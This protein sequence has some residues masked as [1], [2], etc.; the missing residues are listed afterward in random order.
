MTAPPNDPRHDDL[1]AIKGIGQARQEWLRQALDIHTYQDLAALAPEALEAQLKDSGKV[2]S[3]SDIEMWIEQAQHLAAAQP[4]EDSVPTEDWKPFAS[5][6]IEFQ[7]RETAQGIDRR[8]RVHYMEADHDMTWPEIA[9]SEPYQWI[10]DQLGVE[11][12]PSHMISESTEYEEQEPAA[13]SPVEIPEPV[14]PPAQPPRPSEAP[15]PLFSAEMREV[16]AKAERVLGQQAGPPPV[17][18]TP[19]AVPPARPPETSGPLERENLAVHVTHIER[20][21][22]E[23]TSQSGRLALEAQVEV[24]N[25]GE[26]TGK[27]DI[28]FYAQNLTTRSHVYLGETVTASYG[29]GE[30]ALSVRLPGTRLKPGMY[31]LQVMAQQE[32][33]PVRSY[34]D[35][36][37]IQTI[38]S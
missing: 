24:I 30:T 16:L 18:I 9:P 4:A 13:P 12:P 15:H 36:P 28:A 14:L 11:A 10:M 23:P 20:F 2:V 25:T 35:R 17:R 19:S 6:V 1:T 26:Q 21:S 7:R 8:T 32:G 22:D 5:F 34:L 33:T 31:R 37:M 27:L 38:S 3:R 29:K